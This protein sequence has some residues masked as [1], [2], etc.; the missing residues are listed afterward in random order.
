[1][2]SHGSS[3]VPHRL[4]GIPCVQ[5]PHVLGQYV[6]TISPISALWQWLTWVMQFGAVPFDSLFTSL[7][8]SMHGR[9]NRDFSCPN[10]RLSNSVINSNRFQASA[11]HGD[12]GKCLSGPSAS[13]SKRGSY[14]NRSIGQTSMHPM[15][16]SVWTMGHTPVRCLA[17]VV[18]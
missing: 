16:T 13:P 12:L 17:H 7:S 1:M 4:G 8:R 14:L 6:R 9:C 18:K 3:V 15:L 11:T 2:Q 5:M 10:L